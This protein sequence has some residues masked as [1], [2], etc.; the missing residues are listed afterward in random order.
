[1]ATVTPYDDLTG[2]KTISGTWTKISGPGPAAPGAYNGTMNFTGTTDGESVYE[3]EVTS[4]SC[5]HTTSITY[6]SITPDTRVNDDCAGSLT[7]TNLSSQLY[8][9]ERCPGLAAPTDSGVTTPAMWPAS[10]PD[11]W[12]RYFVNTSTTDVDLEFRID[13]SSYS[14]G[15]HQPMLAVYTG[16]CGALVE[17]DS[18]VGTSSV[19]INNVTIPLA[20]TPETIYIRVASIPATAGQFDIIITEL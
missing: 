10:E 3:Y 2:P 9:D 20:S 19:A 15:I 16:T 17:E 5:T 11:I 1:M 6:N 14:D 4:G 7:I 12:F 13:S 8:N 18:V